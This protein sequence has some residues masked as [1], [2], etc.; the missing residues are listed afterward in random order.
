MYADLLRSGP[1]IAFRLNANG[2]V[3]R[4]PVLIV[5]GEVD[6]IGTSTVTE[7]R[8]AF[9]EATVK[10]IPRSGHHPWIEAP[11]AFYGTVNAFLKGLGH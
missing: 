5:Y 9:P 7:L 3:R 1:A 4:I 11:A 10:V 6:A 2:A 8:E